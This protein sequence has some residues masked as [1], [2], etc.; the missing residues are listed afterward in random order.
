M[1]VRREGTGHKNLYKS[2]QFAN[3]S[4]LCILIG[5]N[6]ADFCKEYFTGI[7]GTTS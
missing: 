7:L 4:Y 5:A 6:G 2:S 1:D 3:Y